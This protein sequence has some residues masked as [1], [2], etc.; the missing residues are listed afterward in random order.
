LD[1]TK[2]Q[3]GKSRFALHAVRWVGKAQ[4]G[5]LMDRPTKSE[6][7]S[8]GAAL[9][10][11]AEHVYDEAKNFWRD[12]Y[13]KGDQSHFEPLSRNQV[14]AIEFRTDLPESERKAAGFVEKN[15]D[16]LSKLDGENESLTSKDMEIFARTFDPNAKSDPYREEVM[17]DGIILGGA[18]GSPAGGVAALGIINMDLDV[19]GGLIVGLGLASIVGTIVVAGAIAGYLAYRYYNWNHAGD[20]FYQLNRDQAITT[21]VADGLKS[22]Y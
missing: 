6:D 14:K 13:D 10:A 15:F 17:S 7:A 2:N 9:A 5:M 19:G 11:N 3:P 1:T 20:N 4:E 21:G 16:W 8:S 18:L 22:L 12:T